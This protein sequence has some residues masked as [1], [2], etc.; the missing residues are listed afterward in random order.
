MCLA[1][2]AD[3]GPLFIKYNA[4]LRGQQSDDR[5]TVPVL[6]NAFETLCQGNTYTTTLHVINVAICKLS[7]ITRISRV[8]RAPGGLLPGTFSSEDKF[9][10]C[11]GVEYAFMSA[12]LNRDVALQYASRS[13]AGILFE[14][15]PGL[16]DRGADLAWLSQSRGE[17]D[18]LPT[19][20]RPLRRQQASRGLGAHCRAHGLVALL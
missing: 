15:K 16:A 10:V 17:G 8:Y 4:V 20:L 11:G 9:G 1:V 13:R 6:K 5:A 19:F 2:A 18:L 12:T 3:T 14:L 7:K